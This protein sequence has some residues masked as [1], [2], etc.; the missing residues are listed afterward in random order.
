MTRYT[1]EVVLMDGS[2][3]QVQ[4][5]GKAHTS[6]D[7]V[8]REPMLSFGYSGENGFIRAALVRSAILVREEKVND[9]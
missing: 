1:Y 4:T 2:R 5:L 3:Q 8:L 7:A 9:E 6:F